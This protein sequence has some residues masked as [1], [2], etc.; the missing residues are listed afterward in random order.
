MRRLA[1]RPANLGVLVRNFSDSAL[2]GK[3]PNFEKRHRKEHIEPMF[4]ES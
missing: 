3:K 2:E 1:E 4:A